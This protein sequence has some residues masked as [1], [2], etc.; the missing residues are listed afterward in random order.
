M[1]MNHIIYFVFCFCFS[2]IVKTY[3]CFLKARTAMKTGV[4]LCLMF[5]INKGF[6]KKSEGGIFRV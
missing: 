2:L 4:C 3:G 6:K 5:R 1:C